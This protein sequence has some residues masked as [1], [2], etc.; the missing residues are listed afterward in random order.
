LV[1]VP[2]F[3]VQQRTR[4]TGEVSFLGQ[5]GTLQSQL[6]CDQHSAM[7]RKLDPGWG[8]KVLHARVRKTAPQNW[9]GTFFWGGANPQ[10]RRGWGWAP[11]PHPA[12]GRVGPI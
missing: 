12:E 10:T 11:P 7:Q 1:L 8:V 6:E 2:F 4:E 9:G 3:S 5:T